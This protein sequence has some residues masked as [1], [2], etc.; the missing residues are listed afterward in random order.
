MESNFNIE[1]FNLRNIIIE[2]N[3]ICKNNLD[4]DISYYTITINDKEKYL[5]IL[6]NY[7]KIK[8]YLNKIIKKKYIDYELITKLL[9]AKLIIDIETVKEEEKKGGSNI[10][11]YQLYIYI[12]IIILLIIIK[13]E[14]I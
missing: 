12:T 9:L 3:K 5:I 14:F 11:S 4:N 7:N 8:E 6:H 2:K 1:K 10:K 13:K